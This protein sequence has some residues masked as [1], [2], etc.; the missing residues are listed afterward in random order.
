MSSTKC[1]SGPMTPLS[2]AE[3]V[4]DQ[5][6]HVSVQFASLADVLNSPQRFSRNTSQIERIYRIGQCRV[7]LGFDAIWPRQFERNI[8]YNY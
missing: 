8:N 4:R 7:G 1:V 3:E 2:T 5:Q 6:S